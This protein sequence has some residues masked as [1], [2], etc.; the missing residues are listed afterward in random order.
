MRERAGKDTSIEKSRCKEKK[1]LG[2][3]FQEILVGSVGLG[4]P[5]NFFLLALTIYTFIA[6]DIKE[7][8]F[9]ENIFF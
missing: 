7:F 8:D 9:V 5:K 4:E 2:W 6:L 1:G 3:Q